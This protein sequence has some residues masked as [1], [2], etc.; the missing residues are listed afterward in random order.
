MD[1]EKLYDVYS[2][3]LPCFAE[4]LKLHRMGSIVHFQACALTHLRLTLSMA[5]STSSKFL[6]SLDHPI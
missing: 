3:E 4:L 1:F 2:H 6:I 5:P